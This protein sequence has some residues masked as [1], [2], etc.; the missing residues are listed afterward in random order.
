MLIHERMFSQSANNIHNLDA[1]FQARLIENHHLDTFS[2]YLHLIACAI[3]NLYLFPSAYLARKSKEGLHN[4]VATVPQIRK[5]LLDID[6][7]IKTGCIYGNHDVQLQ[8]HDGQLVEFKIQTFITDGHVGSAFYLKNDADEWELQP[9]T[10]KEFLEKIEQDIR[11][12]P[13]YFDTRLVASCELTA[14]FKTIDNLNETIYKEIQAKS[15]SKANIHFGADELIPRLD[16]PADPQS[17]V[18]INDIDKIVENLLQAGHYDYQYHPDEPSH[19]QYYFTSLSSFVDRYISRNL[20]PILF[21][22]ITNANKAEIVTSIRLL[23]KFMPEH[24]MQELRNKLTFIQSYTNKPVGGVTLDSSSNS[25]MF[26]YLEHCR[27][28]PDAIKLSDLR[29]AKEIIDKL[30][31][32]ADPGYP[33]PADIE[34]CRQLHNE[35]AEILLPIVRQMRK[36]LQDCRENPKEIDMEKFSSVKEFI[37]ALPDPAVPGNPLPAETMALHKQLHH[38]LSNVTFAMNNPDWDTEDSNSQDSVAGSHRI[39]PVNIRIARPM[40]NL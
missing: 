37:D 12:N 22:Q 21:G 7:G 36:Y 2:G 38:E 40:A 10:Y 39:N 31:L 19:H 14:A 35:L 9:F 8:S 27:E 18:L 4:Y 29:L 6:Q 33:L 5:V 28:N 26:R 15:T 23:T 25:L 24:L 30:P 16:D 32:D 11:A 3:K 17:G 34:S 13:T 1:R 20:N